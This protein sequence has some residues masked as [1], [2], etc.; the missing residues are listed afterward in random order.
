MQRKP[1]F[2]RSIDLSRFA[3]KRHLYLLAASFLFLIPLLL[4]W[5]GKSAGNPAPSPSPRLVAST[6]QLLANVRAGDQ[7]ESGTPASQLANALLPASPTHRPTYTPLPDDAGALPPTLTNTATGTASPTATASPSPTQ[8]PTVTPTPDIGREI[9]TTAVILANGL[10]TPTGTLGPRRVPSPTITATA[11]RTATV[12]RTATSTSVPT[13]TPT[14]APVQI[15]YIATVEL[16]L[17]GPD[18]LRETATTTATATATQRPTIT[19]TA[20]ATVVARRVAIQAGHWQ[21][22]KL[23]LALDYLRQNGAAWGGVAEWQINL[24][25]ANATAA[26]LRERGYVVDVLS[27]TVATGYKTDLF[28]ALHSDSSANERARG[29]KA[30]V[31]RGEISKDDMKLLTAIYTEYEAATGI[32][33]DDNITRNMTE[34]YSFAGRFFKY[35][36]DLDTPQAIIEMGFL[37]SPIDR[38]WLLEMEDSCALGVANSVDSYFAPEPTPTAP[39]GPKRAAKKAKR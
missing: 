19:P 34:Y 38:K 30:A 13:E 18:D 31:P 20:S 25:V 2:D 15:E 22:D 9:D 24:A 29:F 1:P 7:A 6:P 33:R 4:S 28:L 16:G 39:P 8:T 10:P 17:M 21:Q 36:A 27:A 26:L 11:T 14:L 37:S 35:A 23:P 5:P 12:T 3:A 32:P